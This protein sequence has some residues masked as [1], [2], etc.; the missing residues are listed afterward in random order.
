MKNDHIKGLLKNLPHLPGV[1]KYYNKEGE[2]IYVGK[3][4]D[5]QK[6]ITS[7]FSK[8]P[9]NKKTF[10]LIKN[11]QGLEFTIVNTEQ[12]ALMLENSLIKHFQPR[13]NI[14]LKDDKSFPYIVITNENF[15]RV[16]LTRN[17]IKDGSEYYGPFTSV[18]KTRGLLEL[19]RNQFP[20][21]KHNQELFIRINE[22]GNLKVSPE[23][24]VKNGCSKE[25]ILN[26]EDYSIIIQQVRNI[27][28]GKF[29]AIIKPLQKEMKACI[30]GMEFENAEV[31]KQKIDFIKEYSLSSKMLNKNIANVDVFSIK[32]EE[33]IAFVN[34]L[35]VS[36][37]LILQTKTIVLKRKNYEANKD[38]IVSAIRHFHNKNK[39]SVVELI[40]PFY[41]SFPNTNFRI[42]VPKSGIRKKLLNLSRKNLDY[43]I[44][45]FK[46][47]QER[48]SEIEIG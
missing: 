19:I 26:Q 9:E 20:L 17:M 10:N 3:A 7:Y 15:P 14:N 33:K 24:Y 34:F 1:Y 38:L 8:T 46:M 13:Y 29:A 27:F 35:Q 42:S 28:K 22:D 39:L 44:D 6:R 37:G 21:R 47:N 45:R 2:L 12:D 41:V 5:L 16:F 31:L 4:K 43:F 36:N 32:V 40:L 48:E 25:Q 18:V 30:E 11:I 23:Y